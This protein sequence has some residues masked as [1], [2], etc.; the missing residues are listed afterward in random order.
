MIKFISG[1]K[2]ILVIILLSFILQL[3]F[4]L[5]YRDTP[6]KSDAIHYDLL[7]RN[8]LYNKIFSLDGKL[9]SVRRPP[10][11]PL[12]LSALYWVFGESIL[13]VQIVQAILITA[14]CFLLYLLGRRIFN[15][16]TALVAAFLFAIY[17]VFVT[18]SFFIL[19]ESLMTFLIT[20]AVFIGFLCLWTHKRIY[21]ILLGLIFGIS[22]LCKAIV[23]LLP[24]F[25]IVL[26]VFMYGRIKAV[27]IALLILIPFLLIISLW[28]GRNFYFTGYFI[29]VQIGAGGSLWNGTYVPGKGFEEDPLTVKA[30]RQLFK[31]L[32]NK[33]RMEQADLINEKSAQFDI[34]TYLIIKEFRKEAFQNLYSD[35][36]GFLKILPYKFVRLYI[37]S[38]CYLYGVKEK[39]SDLFA[40]KN[41]INRNK[42]IAIKS[43]LVALS[44]ATLIFAFIGLFSLRKRFRD[45]LPIVIL[46]LYWN[47]FFIFFDTMTR[48]SIPIMPVLI[49][50][51]AKG[52]NV[53]WRRLRS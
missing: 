48:Y 19:S 9:I 14:S 43:S 15:E 53:S 50:L 35:P 26:L 40:D 49:L 44:F 2:V 46:L 33:V 25:S 47:I 7:A 37:G 23:L 10:V 34:V 4:I 51:A 28:V 24:I 22:A 3:C 17:P 30:K 20:L 29:P 32:D 1:N 31:R 16:Q 5:N 11:Y 27:K 41:I 38:Y 42:K 39:F 12:F 13:A 18:Q 52:I 45:I 8:L 6:I 36:V 21:Y